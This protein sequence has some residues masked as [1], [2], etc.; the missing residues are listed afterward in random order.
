MQ[1]SPGPSPLLTAADHGKDGKD[2][3]L[4]GAG[5]KGGMAGI[6]HQHSDLVAGDTKAVDDITDGGTRSETARLYFE[7]VV[8]EIGKQFDRELHGFLDYRR[9]NSDGETIILSFR[10]AE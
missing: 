7:A 4:G 10:G 9:F 6:D 2:V 8:A 5:G 1:Y 3:S